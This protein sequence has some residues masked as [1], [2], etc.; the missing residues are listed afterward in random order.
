MINKVKCVGI[1]FCEA[2]AYSLPSITYATGGT[3]DYVIND[4]NGYGISLNKSGE[5]FANSVIKIMN[6]KNKL[7]EMK[8]NARKMYEQDLNW[9]HFGEKLEDIINSLIIKD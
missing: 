4:I 3:P 6:E 9:K 8:Y 5:E 7:E 1:V 2:C